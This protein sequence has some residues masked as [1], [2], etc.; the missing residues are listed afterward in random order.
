MLHK[1]AQ[2]LFISDQPSPWKI[3]FRVI[4]LMIMLLASVWW[5][6]SYQQAADQN[7]QDGSEDK[8]VSDEQRS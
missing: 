5:V 3:T 8:Q 2:E 6:K 1:S 4:L 7:I